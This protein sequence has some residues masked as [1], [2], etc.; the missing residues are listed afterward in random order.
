MTDPRIESL[1]LLVVGMAG[2]MAALTFLAG[3]IWMFRAIDEWLNARRIRA[4]TTQVES[5]GVQELINDE[6]V[7]VLAAAAESALRKPVRVRRVQ[8]L[9]T[10]TRDSWAATGRLNIMASHSIAKRK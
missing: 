10:A 6:L 3:M 9:A 1:L 5:G 2:V 4:Y 7:A 8:F